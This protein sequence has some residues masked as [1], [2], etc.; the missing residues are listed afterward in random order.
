MKHIG[1]PQEG[2]VMMWQAQ[3]GMGWWMLFGG[4]WMVLFWA[5]LIGLGVWLLN[6]ITARPESQSPL[7]IAKQRLARGELTLEQYEV[8]RQKL[9]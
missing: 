8:L 4:L 1:Q 7:D 9:S 5:V 6:R 2:K 3:E